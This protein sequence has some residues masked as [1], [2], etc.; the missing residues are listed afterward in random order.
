MK[1]EGHDKPIR[2]ASQ[3]K[4]FPHAVAQPP[5]EP[6]FVRGSAVNSRRC[7]RWS[8]AAGRCP[9]TRKLRSAHAHHA[10][11]PPGLSWLAAYVKSNRRTGFGTA[12][13]DDAAQSLG[14]GTAPGG[15]RPRRC[16]LPGLWRLSTDTSDRQNC[17][18][19]DRRAALTLAVRRPAGPVPPAPLPNCRRGT[20]GRCARLLR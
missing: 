2:G 11:D 3:P 14:V 19:A 16:I 6:R 4:S 7:A 15:H 12:A 20:R 9:H 1:R 17:Y 8:G 10:H 5:A 18:R 13:E